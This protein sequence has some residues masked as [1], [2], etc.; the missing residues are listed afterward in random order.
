MRIKII[1]THTYFSNQLRKADD[2]SKGKRND[3]EMLRKLG[4]SR[5]VESLFRFTYRRDLPPCSLAPYNSISS[6]AGWGCML[7]A[8]QMM[9]AHTMRVHFL[10]KGQ[11]FRCLHLSVL[12]TSF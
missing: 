9:M 5:H 2:D 3:K 4:M 8:A 12:I 1:N 6:D 10:G 11:L 7:R